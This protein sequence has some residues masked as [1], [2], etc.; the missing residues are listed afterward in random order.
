MT[1][2]NDDDRIV[3]ITEGEFDAMAVHQEM[4]VPAV[5]LPNGATHLPV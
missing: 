5:S 3:V 4:G 1:T 2:I